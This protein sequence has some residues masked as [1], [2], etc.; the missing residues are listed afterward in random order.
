MPAPSASDASGT[1]PRDESPAASPVPTFAAPHAPPPPGVLISSAPPTSR[2]KRPLGTIALVLA[3]IA[4]VLAPA[5]A[6]FASFRVAGGAGDEFFARGGTS[7]DWTVLSPV[8]DFVLMAEVSF[9][10]GTAL[11]IGAFVVGIGATARK[12][13]RGSGITAIVLAALGPVIFGVAVTIAL[14]AGAAGVSNGTGIAT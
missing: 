5:V 12:L 9:W 8:R 2:G 7:I 14:V 3:I 6:G 10:G 1:P 11:G 4:A 13:G